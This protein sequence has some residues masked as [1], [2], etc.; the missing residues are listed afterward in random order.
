MLDKIQPF[1]WVTAEVKQETA[2]GRGRCVLAV[3]GPALA[4]RELTGF[5]P[6]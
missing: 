2:K 1:S 3:F 6:R 4:S 5:L